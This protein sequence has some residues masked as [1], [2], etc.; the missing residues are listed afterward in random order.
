MIAS[1]VIQPSVHLPDVSPPWGEH[2]AQVDRTRPAPPDTESWRFWVPDIAQFDVKNNNTSRTAR[3]FENWL[4]VRPSWLWLL[5]Q[6]AFVSHTTALKLP[7][8]RDWRDVLTADP[9]IVNK[10]TFTHVERFSAVYTAQGHPL[11]LVPMSANVRTAQERKRVLWELATVAMRV[12]LHAL[13]RS[14]VR[15]AS[16][17]H[18]VLFE[19]ERIALI[20]RVFGGEPLSSEYVAGP[21]MGFSAYHIRDRADGLEAF[22]VIVSRWPGA[23]PAIQQASPL[24]ASSGSDTIVGMEHLI[25]GWYLQTFWDC[26]GRAA[27]VPRIFPMC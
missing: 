16:G 22:R 10:G 9:R 1:F 20:R 26:A 27:A 5:Q 19:A 14:L 6:D 25:A 18:A 8:G 12:E 11:P 13:D 17:Q 15:A 21:N 23:P 3:S 7:R 2:L 24:T 4:A